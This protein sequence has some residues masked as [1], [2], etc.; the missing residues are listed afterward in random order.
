MIPLSVLDL[1]FAAP[2]S[3]PSNLAL[4]LDGRV[5]PAVLQEALDTVTSRFT[6]VRSRLLRADART[7]VFAPDP[8]GPVLEHVE[9]DVLPRHP[10]DL[11]HH[12]P[13]VRTVP[14][15]PL[16]RF[17][18]L[19]DGQACA[20]LVSFSHVLGD[21]SACFDFLVAWGRAA[22][23]RPGPEPSLDRSIFDQIFRSAAKPALGELAATG[24]GEAKPGRRIAAEDFRGVRERVFTREQLERWAPRGTV[25]RFALIAGAIWE[26]R[27]QQALPGAEVGLAVPV[28]LRRLLEELPSTY[29]GNA[30]RPAVVRARREQ[31]LAWSPLER[32]ERVQRAIEAV[33]RESLAVDHARVSAAVRAG[34]PEAIWAQ[35]VTGSDTTLVSDISYAPVGLVRFGDT[36]CTGLLPISL[37]ARSIAVLP[38]PDGYRTL[39]PE[40]RPGVL[41]LARSL[42]RG[43]A[44][45]VLRSLG[46]REVVPRARPLHRALLEFATQEGLWQDGRPRAAL[47]RPLPG[48][49]LLVQ[50]AATVGRDPVAFAWLARALDQLE[51]V[52]VGSI[53]GE[54][55]LFGDGFGL[56]SRLYR[57]SPL[58][59]WF[60]HEA[61]LRLQGRSR[62]LELGA[63]TGAVPRPEGAERYLFTDIAEPLLE[64]ARSWE[65]PGLEVRRLDMDAPDWEVGPVDTV[66]LV[67]VLH[68]SVD[69]AAVIRR[70]CD[71]LEPGGIVVLAEIGP[72]LSPLMGLSFGQLPSYPH[73]ER[74]PL[75]PLPVW[76]ALLAEAGLGLI[77]RVEHLVDD[78]P[79]GGLLVARR[80]PDAT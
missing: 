72:A 62:I 31:V 10:L 32:A 28:D 30:L 70:I 66:V 20:L 5:D 51:P 11:A 65:E 46:D 38:H 36:R 71:V 9:V 22:S 43:A 60:A 15:E 16:A 79:V 4:F 73:A 77:E 7:L 41:E 56:A 25:P 49:E 78:V 39:Q 6:P 57:E 3:R 80:S 26:E 61:G 68:A 19:D 40:L 58:F 8:L 18:L 21:A 76:T 74:S 13:G 47:L 14:G 35:K 69:P 12:L 55:A 1:Y 59:G 27:A 63:G 45:R 52:L 75:R 48:S 54:Q 17:V 29:F 33:T 37:Y 44:G 42:C 2:D 53:T 64:A 24:I 34:G 50:E 23:G 67:N